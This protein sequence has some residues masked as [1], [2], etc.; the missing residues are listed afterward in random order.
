M[1][2]TAIIFSVFLLFPVLW[3]CNDSGNSSSADNSQQRIFPA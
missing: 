3:G 2:L 1:K